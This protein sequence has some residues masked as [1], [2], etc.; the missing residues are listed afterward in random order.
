[1]STMNIS[2]PEEMRSW[3]EEEVQ[4]GGFA[5]ASE[6]FRQLLRDA[7]ARQDEQAQR[8][9]LQAFLIQGIESGQVQDADASWWEALRSEVGAST[10]SKPL[11]PSPGDQP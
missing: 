7:R 11:D 2:L 6:Y 5:S 10:G 8:A 4:R 1:M 9:R 3:V